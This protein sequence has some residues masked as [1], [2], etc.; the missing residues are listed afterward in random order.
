MNSLLK[1]PWFGPGLGASLYL[2]GMNDELLHL[3]GNWWLDIG[4]W[5]QTAAVL[6]AL[7]VIAYFTL[8]ALNRRRSAYR[9]AVR[10]AES[11]RPRT[12]QSP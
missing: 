2:T 4:R 11:T 1:L 10:A 3:L 6:A 12:P 9:S 5:G 7:A 8:N